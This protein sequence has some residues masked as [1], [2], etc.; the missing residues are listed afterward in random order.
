MNPVL[1]ASHVC[2]TYPDGTQ[3]IRD[4]TFAVAA[5]ESVG[6]IG[7]NGAG[8]STLLL[9]LVGCLFPSEGT[10]TVGGIVAKANTVTAIRQQVGLVFQNPDDQLFMPTVQAD[11]SFG[12][13]NQGLTE[14]EVRLRV[15][16]ALDAVGELHLLERPPYRLSGG[17]KRAVSI[18]TVLA[19]E[20][21]ILVLDEPS[22]GLDPTARRKVI[23][24]LRGFNHTRIVASHD[25]D[26]VL[27][28]CQRVILMRA[29]QVIADGICAEILRNAQ[30]LSD[31][32]LELPLSLQACPV[33]NPVPCGRT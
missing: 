15:R 30:L 7:A 3:A 9:H 19:M 21:D 22:A 25:L 32:G 2:H 11:V 28:M 14:E 6:I 17:E 27:E 26:L 33:C 20:P 18:A 5:G 31:C 16:Q 29:G 23:R 12:P 10:L 1:E 8:K 4:V 24:L 13:R